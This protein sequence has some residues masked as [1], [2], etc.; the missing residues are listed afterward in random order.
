MAMMDAKKCEVSKGLKVTVEEEEFN[1]VCVPGCT[2]ISEYSQDCACA[3]RR[4]GLSL[5]YCSTPASTHTLHPS[6]EM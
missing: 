4:W 1:E 5:L 3:S 6:E 2:L